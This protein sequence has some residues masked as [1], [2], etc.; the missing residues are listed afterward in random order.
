MLKDNTKT[1]VIEILIVETTMLKIKKLLEGEEDIKNS[2]DIE[3]FKPV[4]RIGKIG[5]KIFPKKL[6]NNIKEIENKIPMKNVFF[7]NKLPNKVNV[8]QTLHSIESDYKNY[9]YFFISDNTKMKEK[10]IKF[11]N[12][13]E[14]EINKF[15]ENQ[16]NTKMLVKKLGEKN[17]STYS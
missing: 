9:N 17:G 6:V 5:N 7:D 2:F 13:A 15:N 14:S 4:Y 16:Y 1:D 8:K 3:E 11:V 10:I 12:G